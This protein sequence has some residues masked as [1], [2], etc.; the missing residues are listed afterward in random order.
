MIENVSR[1][2]P[3][4]I[5]TAADGGEVRRVLLE[6]FHRSPSSLADGILRRGCDRGGGG[7]DG[8]G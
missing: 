2:A 8:G 1:V 6:I 4:R 5:L 3:S 7:D